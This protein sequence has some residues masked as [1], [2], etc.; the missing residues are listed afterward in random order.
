M[1]S[2]LIFFLFC[3]GCTTALYRHDPVEGIAIQTIRAAQ[4][5]SE[6][7]RAAVPSDPDPRCEANARA[8]DWVVGLPGISEIY[9]VDLYLARKN[10]NPN[11]PKYLD[12]GCV[13]NP[14]SPQNIAQEESK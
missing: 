1:K 12:N 9:A 10:P 13:L 5:S 3:S 14:F 4:K 6:E 11:E 7:I 8:W 2:L